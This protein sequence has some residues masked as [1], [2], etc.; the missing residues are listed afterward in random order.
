MLFNLGRF[1]ESLQTVVSNSRWHIG[2]GKSVNFWCDTW[3]SQPIMDMLG[4]PMTCHSLL[5]AFVWDFIKDGNWCIHQEML[6]M[7]AFLNFMPLTV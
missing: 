6:Q 3:L 5:I 1:K 2:D 7:S 4:I